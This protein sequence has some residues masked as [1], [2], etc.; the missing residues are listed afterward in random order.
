MVTNLD[1]AMLPLLDGSFVHPASI[2][3][4]E[5]SVNAVG[6]AKNRLLYRPEDIG[7]P[8]LSNGMT[9]NECLGNSQ[10][11]VNIPLCGA[12]I[13]SPHWIPFASRP[14]PLALELI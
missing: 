12:D 4:A 7:Q 10:S 6:G 13:I 11:T 9:G 8:V 5:V 2:G 3:R 14:T 1:A